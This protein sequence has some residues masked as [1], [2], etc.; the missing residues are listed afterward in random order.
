MPFYSLKR[1]LHR[2]INPVNLL[3]KIE[4]LFSFVST[5]KD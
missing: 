5:E 2:R 4:E 1:K 3:Q